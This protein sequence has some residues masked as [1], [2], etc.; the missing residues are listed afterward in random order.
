MTRRRAPGDPGV[1][2]NCLLEFYL[3]RH[4]ETEWSLN[5]VANGRHVDVPLR[6]WGE[7]TGA[8]PR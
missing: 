8:S 5:S 1:N 3:I 6:P 7:R 4:G 2:H